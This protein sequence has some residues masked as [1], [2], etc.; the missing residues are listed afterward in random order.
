MRCIVANRL[1]SDEYC[2][3]RQYLLI[4]PREFIP[5]I[6][7][8]TI[9][10]VYHLDLQNPTMPSF[11]EIPLLK[12]SDAR[13][14][15]TKPAFL[16]SLRDALLNVGFLYLSE[17]GLPHS[18]IDNVIHEC[19]AFFEDLSEE[20]KLKVEMKNQQSFLGYSRL[21]NEITAGKADWR[22]QMDLVS[23]RHDSLSRIEHCACGTAYRAALAWKLFEVRALSLAPRLEPK[24]ADVERLYAR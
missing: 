5:P 23:E 9:S 7:L 19:R 11:S 21:G 6:Y 20:E 22:E 8:T 10:L 3:I 13:N 4:C 15:T 12:L 24:H 17:T 14:L 16:V 2:P 1:P 18:L